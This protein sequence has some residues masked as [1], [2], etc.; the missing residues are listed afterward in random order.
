MPTSPQPDPKPNA[1]L[2]NKANQKLNARPR[3]PARSVREIRRRQRLEAE[4]EH[5]HSLGDRLFYAVLTGL[6]Y[7]AVG[8]VLDWIIA[9]VRAMLD[10]GNGDVFWLFAPFLLVLGALIGFFDGK[11]ASSDSMEAFTA[12]PD[13]KYDDL[14]IRHDIFRGLG[15]GIFLFALMWLVMMI[16][17]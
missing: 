1:K 3:R 6:M 16:L 4:G 2:S 7:G 13:P 8:V 9:L 12:E 10:V 11:F 17:I 5:Y 14:S 15:I